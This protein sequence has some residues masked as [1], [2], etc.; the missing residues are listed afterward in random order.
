MTPSTPRFDLPPING[1]VGGR[2]TLL[3][4]GVTTAD[5]FLIRIRNPV[6]SLVYSKLVSLDTGARV[7]FQELGFLS[8]PAPVDFEGS[9]ITMEEPGLVDENGLQW[10]DGE[11]GVFILVTGG[12]EDQVLTLSLKFPPG[13]LE[14]QILTLTAA[15]VLSLQTYTVSFSG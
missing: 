12:E 9:P 3:L 4:A 8:V 1:R 15:A 5:S 10:G 11:G 2:A 13:V 14:L 6:S 7:K